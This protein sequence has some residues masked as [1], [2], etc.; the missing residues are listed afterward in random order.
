MNNFLLQMAD[1]LDVQSIGTAD[2][3]ADFQEWDSLSMLSVIAMCDSEY[4]VNLTAADLRALTTVSELWQT[5]EN[6]MKS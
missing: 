6:K 5:I 1:I 2:I 4:G 3:L